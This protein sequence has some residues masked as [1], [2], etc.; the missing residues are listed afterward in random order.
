VSTV[1]IHSIFTCLAFT[2]Y[3]G[4]YAMAKIDVK[5]ANGN[6]W[7]SCIHETKQ[8]VNSSSNIDS[9]RIMMFCYP[10]GN[11]VYKATEGIVW[12]YSI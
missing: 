5:G 2:L 7:I 3:A 8:K 4:N 10:R 11:A 1:S 9:S 12:L 6:V